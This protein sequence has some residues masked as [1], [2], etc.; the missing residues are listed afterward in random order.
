MLWVWGVFSSLVF[1][2]GLLF[3]CF[4]KEKKY[5]KSYK[6]NMMVSNKKKDRNS[7]IVDDISI[8]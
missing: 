6:K 3:A 4:V 2:W 8:T 7:H 1:I 5:L